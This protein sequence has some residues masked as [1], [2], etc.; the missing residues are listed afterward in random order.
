MI[1]TMNEIGIKLKEH[2]ENEGI[3]QKEV[4]ER[5]GVTPQY[6]NALLQGRKEIG[7][8]MAKK[9]E[10]QF[11]LS[12]SWLLTGMGD[13][14]NNDKLATPAELANIPGVLPEIEFE[15]AAGQTLLVSEE[16]KVNRYWYLPDCRDCEAVVPIQGTSMQPDFPAGCYAAMKRY[17]IP[18]NNP[19]AIPFGQVFGVVVEDEVTGEWHGYVKVLRRH[20]DPDFAKN[21]WIA[22]SFNPDFDDFDI[23]LA[24]V[25]SLWIV[26]QHIVNDVNY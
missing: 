14:R 8:T 24:Q 18:N 5:L 22:H 3:T 9:L 17:N 26:K 20:K 4:A 10:N 2:F 6:V 11:G 12:Q 23:P 16:K 13:M 21:Y 25:K 7:K 19:N 1:N 15:F